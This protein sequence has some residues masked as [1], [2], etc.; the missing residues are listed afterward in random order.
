MTRTTSGTLAVAIAL[1][2]A[3]WVARP[4]AAQTKKDLPMPQDHPVLRHTD[5]ESHTL[6]IQV[7]VL[8]AIVPQGYSSRGTRSLEIQRWD[9][10]SMSVILPVITTT[11]NAIGSPDSVTGEMWIDSRSVD[12]TPTLI[13]PYQGQSMY[14]RYE[15]VNWR[16]DGFRVRQQETIVCCETIYDEQAAMQL[17]WPD[18][19]PPEADSTFQPEQLISE[20]RSDFNNDGP[21]NDLVRKWTNGQDPK[22][23]PP[24][25]LA[26]YLTAKVWEHV[27]VTRPPLSNRP[28]DDGT[29]YPIN[30]L[31]AG[32]KQNSTGYSRAVIAQTVGYVVQHADETATTGEGSDNDAAVLLTAVFRAAGLPARLV[33]GYREKSE[34]IRRLSDSDKNHTWVEF[35]LYD[36]DA[37]EGKGQLIWVPVD[38]I[39]LK[40]SSS[41][42]RPLD[43]PWKYFG[44][45][46]DL[47]ELVPVATHFHPP[48]T[49]RSYAVPAL[50]GWTTSPEPPDTASQSIDLNLS[51]TVIRG[52]DDKHTP[53]P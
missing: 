34:H 33:I 12:T 23:I 17:T 51:G 25:Q 49:V 21:V 5:P 39:A 4:A 31:A 13:G 14:A 41:R 28:S 35:A 18:A 2:L 27:R 45:H 42:A 53:A 1:G 38:I 19:W 6:T 40:G 36:P 26:K 10:D 24:A 3:P 8:T 22:S 44:T 50:Y 15:A 47:D 11:G 48:T 20:V 32:G 52:D 16:L 29:V 30:L 43:Q 46:D 7:Q 9:V 37:N